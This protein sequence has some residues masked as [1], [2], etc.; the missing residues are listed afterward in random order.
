MTHVEQLH[1]KYMI[2][3]IQRLIEQPYKKN[4]NIRIDSGGM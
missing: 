1:F 4:I 3:M 2:I